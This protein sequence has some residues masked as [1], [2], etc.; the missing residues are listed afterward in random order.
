MSDAAVRASNRTG[1]Q[2]AGPASLLLLVTY[3]CLCLPNT[4]ARGADSLSSHCDVSPSEK[5]SPQVFFWVGAS[6]NAMILVPA[7]DRQVVFVEH[8]FQ[9]TETTIIKI[10]HGQIIRICYLIRKQLLGSFVI[11]VQRV[12]GFW[13][14]DTASRYG[15]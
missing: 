2:R 13:M 15:R 5:H 1:R 10:G 14:G 4:L 6:W 3:L 9:S 12:L 7:S 8:S 11:T